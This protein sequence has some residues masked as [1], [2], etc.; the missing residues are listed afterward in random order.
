MQK[1]DMIRTIMFLNRGKLLLTFCNFRKISYARNISRI[2]SP[3]KPLC[4]HQIKPDSCIYRHITSSSS[5]F[6]W[7]TFNKV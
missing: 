3:F 7:I 1:P 2:K 6:N 4:I 5:K